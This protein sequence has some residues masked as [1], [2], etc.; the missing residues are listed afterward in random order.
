MYF[1]YIICKH[2]GYTGPFCGVCAEN[3]YYDSFNQVCTICESTGINAFAIVGIVLI[4]LLSMAAFMY[5]T[6]NTVIH[7]EGLKIN[8]TNLVTRPFLEF[9]TK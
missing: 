5:F 7:T 6:W 4:A 9:F 8:D 3:Y 1:A 2:T